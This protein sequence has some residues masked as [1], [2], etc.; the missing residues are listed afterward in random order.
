MRRAF[1]VLWLG[2]LLCGCEGSIGDFQPI[3]GGGAG[4]GG[5]V[6][7]PPDVT[8]DPNIPTTVRIEDAIAVFGTDVYP[9]LTTGASGCTSCHADGSGRRFIVSADATTTFYQARSGGFFLDQPGNLL[10]RVSAVDSFVRMPQAAPALPDSVVK[11]IAQV[12]CMVRTYEAN[13]GP[14]ADEQFPPELLMP[15]GGQPISSYDNPFINY[16]QLKSKVKS[17]FNDDWV[18]AGENQFDKNIGLFGGVNFTTHFVEAR[19]ATAEF[20]LGLD[21]LAPDVCGAAAT[22]GTGPF[23][24]LALADAI[25]DV[26]AQTDTTF[27]FENLTPNPATGAGQA[28]TN[29][30]GYFCYTNCDFSAPY[31]VPAPGTYRVLVRGKPTLDGNGDGPQ[32]TAQ[33]GTATTASTMLWS[34]ATLYEDKFVDITVTAP[35]ATAVT[36][37]F[38][39]DAV[40]NGGDRNIY[41]D[42]MTVRGPLGTGTGTARADA[43][44]AKIDVLYQRMLYRPATQAEKNTTYALLTDLATLGTLNSAWSGVCEALVR[45]PDFLF[46]MAP[47]VE[48]AATAASDKERLRLV[49]LTQRVLGR[50]PNNSEFSQLDAAG[51]SSVVDAVFASQDFR[52]Y[53]FNRI[54]L[55]IESQGTPESDEPARIWTW[56]TTTGRSFEE[57]LTADY[58]VDTNFQ[59]Q[60]RPPE[61]G[62]TGVLTSKGYVSNKPGLPHYNYPARV[63]SGFMGSIFEVPPEVFAQ[64]GTAT[65]ASTVDPS[66]ICFNCHQLLTPLAHQRLKW[67]DD[68]TFR[69]TLMGQPIDDTDRGL[70]ATYAYKG[71]GMEA[72]ATKAVKKEPF[73]RRM[74]NTQFKLLL[75]REMRSKDDERVI[76]KQLWDTTFA[77]GGDMRPVLKSVANSPTFRGAP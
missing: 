70:V 30:A 42:S 35:G 3:G 51:W 4:G 19:V 40:I 76:Y 68:G 64:R 54:R 18:R 23:A 63:F 65:A 13:G 11:A 56:V 50:P 39:N 43:A 48:L 28:S 24:G 17:V 58:T 61:H 25:A 47:T 66:S 49:A 27:Q 9:A 15:Y 29:P 8:C 26:P 62:K 67:A 45:H 22:N 14:P 55:R 1:A 33:I 77:N 12:G 59:Q 60:P 5:E 74:I 6:Y 34:N 36:V 57:V 75:G 53:Y 44:K 21:V 16:V 52:D 69:D 37:S 20:L 72:F 7:V 31:T 38:F 41:L 10:A 32:L 73:I 2:S 71:A 46:T